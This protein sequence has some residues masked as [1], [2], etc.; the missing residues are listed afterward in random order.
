MLVNFLETLLGF[1][2]V[3]DQ[4]LPHLPKIVFNITVMNSNDGAFKSFL[5]VVVCH[6]DQQLFQLLLMFYRVISKNAH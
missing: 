1:P 3:E 6:I 4:Y 5:I 2:T